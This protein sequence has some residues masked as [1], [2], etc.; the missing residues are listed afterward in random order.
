MAF[1]F[2]EYPVMLLGLCLDN[3]RDDFFC[4]ESTGIKFNKKLLKN[5]VKTQNRTRSKKN[6]PWDKESR[7]CQVICHFEYE[8]A[9]LCLF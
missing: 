1:V 2:Q 7:R 9:I 8:N 3:L 5:L 6:I 4:L